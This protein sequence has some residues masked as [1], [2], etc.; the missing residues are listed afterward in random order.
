MPIFMDRH[1]VPGSTAEDVAEAHRK[2]VEIQDKYGVR[3]MTYWHDAERG[4]GFCLVD[5][6]DAATAAHVHREAHGQIPSDIIP[7]DLAAVE[8]FLGRIGDPRMTSSS[9][10]PPIDTGLRAIVVTDIVGS[11]ELTA[12]LGDVA[13]LELI[14]V[15]DAIVRRALARHDG[16]EVKHIGDGIMAAF[17][18][19]A[20]AVRAAADIQLQFQKYNSEATESLRV[21]IGI[22]AGEPV[23]DHNDLFD[24]TVQMAFRLCS[25]AEGDVILVSE[26]VRELSG[27]DVSRFVPIGERQ[28]KGFA[29]KTPVF[30]FE[31]RADS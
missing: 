11:T 1:D 30:R 25:E 10:A 20:N 9:V 5:A 7:V 31:W 27:E 6:P 13:A 16:R 17:G 8:A 15:H 12:R 18:Q 21:R 2:D 23:A 3:Y 19:V 28:L 4:T 14:R 22:H 24:A 26:L 29:A